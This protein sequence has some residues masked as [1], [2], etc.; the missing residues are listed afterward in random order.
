M[1]SAQIVGCDDGPLYSLLTSSV[2]HILVCIV[3][4]NVGIVPFILEFK[5]CSVYCNLAVFNLLMIFRYVCTVF[6]TDMLI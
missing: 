6:D 5:C 1:L 2:F 4:N 3:L